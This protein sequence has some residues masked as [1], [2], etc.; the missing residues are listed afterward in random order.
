MS[1]RIVINVTGATGQCSR[2]GDELE[3]LLASIL[4]HESLHYFGFVPGNYTI[5]GDG[6][7]RHAD[8]PEDILE[9][10]FPSPGT[11]TGIETTPLPLDPPPTPG[12]DRSRFAPQ[13]ED[14]RGQ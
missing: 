1:K 14:R 6:Q 9:Q 3:Y 2:S 13:P 4:L 7:E 12:L 5:L 10:V 8:W 11:A